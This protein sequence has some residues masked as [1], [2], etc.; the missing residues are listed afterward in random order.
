M[1]AMAAAPFYDLTTAT[2]RTWKRKAI[3]FVEINVV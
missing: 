1:V 2:A 3:T